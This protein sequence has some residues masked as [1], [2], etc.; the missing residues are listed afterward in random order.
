MPRPTNLQIAEVLEQVAQ[1]LEIKE[2][3]AFRV[4]AYLRAARSV[5]E[6]QQPLWQIFATEGID[7]LHRIPGVGPTIGSIIQQYIETGRVAM[8][9]R[10]MLEVLPEH[11]FTV[12]PGIGPEL[13]TRISQQLRV[14]TL[15]DLELA[16]HDGRLAALP[17]FGARRT[18]L[19]RDALAG[20]L[21]RSRTRTRS[22]PASR[23]LEIP[24]V[25][26]ILE[27]D[28]EYRRRAQSGELKRIAPRRFSPEGKAWLPLLQT[29][30]H[31]WSFT[32][33]FSNTARAHQ[34]GKTTDWVVIFYDR[35]Q[36]VGQCTVVTERRGLMTGKRVVRG[37]EAECRALYYLRG[38]PSAI[39]T[40]HFPGGGAG[41]LAAAG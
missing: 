17:G 18:K 33:L 10:L 36:Q 39:D 15:E 24:A 27:I 5:S 3:D 21:A 22:A 7:G 11:L 35:G 32:A 30:R 9:E 23:D 16:A 20:I 4:S 38:V 19:V 41:P 25:E 29:K 40:D 2:A 37:R 8:L 6:T 31:A 13:A 28:A 26:L 34:L 1:L 14:H 12:V